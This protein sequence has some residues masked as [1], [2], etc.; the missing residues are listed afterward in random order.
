IQTGNEDHIII[1]VAQGLCEGVV[2][3]TVKTQRFIYSR[4]KNTLLNR[5]I[6]KRKKIISKF[7]VDALLE[8]AQSLEY[9]MGRTQDIEWAI[10]KTGCIW[11]VQT[12][13]I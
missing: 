3:G 1:D 10:D 5:S 7:E 6:D 4:S 8:M 13:S 12:R 9:Q 11:L 2:D